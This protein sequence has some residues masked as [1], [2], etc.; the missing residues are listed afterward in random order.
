MRT[1]NFFKGL[2][3]AA[4]ALVGVFA[5]S[6]SE[7]E[8]NIKPAAP[9]TLP[10]PKVEVTINVIDLGD[11]GVGSTLLQSSKDIATSSMGQKK[12]YTCPVIEGYTVAADQTID[13]PT[14]EKGQAAYLTVNFFIVKWTS[15]LAQVVETDL[16]DEVLDWMDR[17]ASEYI[18]LDGEDNDKNWTNP[19]IYQREITGFTYEYTSGLFEK[20]SARAATTSTEIIDTYWNNKLEG[21]KIEATAESWGGIVLDAY[22]KLMVEVQKMKQNRVIELKLGNTTVKKECVEYIEVYLSLN[23]EAMSSHAHEYNH[24]QTHGQHGTGDNAGGGITW[25]E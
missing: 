25:A 22:A 13:I 10:E 9:A 11:T 15:A 21:S 7:E 23:Q 12:T 17:D 3:V 14:L 8:L 5:T 24:Y 6:C 19:S 2:A 18:T 4:V 16:T 20:A 1:K